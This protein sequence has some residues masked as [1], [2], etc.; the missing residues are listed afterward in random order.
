[1][2]SDTLDPQHYSRSSKHCGND[3][4]PTLANITRIGLAPAH[5]FITSPCPMQQAL[6]TWRACTANDPMQ[7]DEDDLTKKTPANSNALTFTS[8]LVAADIAP[9]QVTSL[10]APTVSLRFT[11][12]MIVANIEPVNEA[13][14]VPEVVTVKPTVAAVRV[15]ADYAP[16]DPVD[17]SSADEN[18][19]THTRTNSTSSA[20]STTST[21]STQTTDSHWSNSTSTTS[22]TSTD[23]KTQESCLK[24]SLKLIPDIVVDDSLHCFA[25]TTSVMPSIAPSNAETSPEAV[26]AV[27]QEQSEAVDNAGGSVLNFIDHY[28]I[29]ADEITDEEWNQLMILEAIR[30]D[31]FSQELENLSFDTSTLQL[32]YDSDAQDL[33]DTSANDL[34]LS[35]LLPF[36]DEIDATVKAQ[37]ATDY[38][39]VE[40]MVEDSV[41]SSGIPSTAPRKFRVRTRNMAS[42]P[43]ARMFRIRGNRRS[44][45]INVTHSPHVR[46]IPNIIITE[47]EE[48]T[49]PQSEVTRDQQP[50]S[51]FDYATRSFFLQVPEPQQ[52]R[53]LTQAPLNS[54]FEFRATGVNFAPS[55]PNEKE[56]WLNKWAEKGRRGTSKASKW[57]IN[58]PT[59]RE[60]M[61]V[62]DECNF[63]PAIT[64]ETP[65]ARHLDNFGEDHHLKSPDSLSP[66][67]S[68]TSRLGRWSEA[69]EEVL[70]E[71]MDGNSGQKCKSLVDIEDT[72]QPTKS[73]RS[74]TT[75]HFDDLYDRKNE[76]KTHKKGC[77][78]EEGYYR[79]DPHVWKNNQ[80]KTSGIEETRL[81]GGTSEKSTQGEVFEKIDQSALVSA[82]CHR[83]GPDRFDRWCEEY[84]TPISEEIW[85]EI[86]TQLEEYHGAQSEPAPTYTEY[87]DVV[88][89]TPRRHSLPQET[90]P[91]RYLRTR[92]S[93]ER[94]EDVLTRLRLMHCRLE[95]WAEGKDNMRYDGDF[96]DSEEH[97]YLE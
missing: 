28:G 63:L 48:F 84:A 95:R 15:V 70:D 35:T 11:P 53:S 1:M 41:V 78:E 56:E 34:N 75:Y 39:Q 58:A 97:E 14:E 82:L 60:T 23:S 16:C 29:D 22:L 30:G 43:C 44:P 50:D 55:S 21:A 61:K 89:P 47:P 5:A 67:A 10:S 91:R 3:Y 81:P 76:G 12:N 32:A 42:S 66:P 86:D 85:D 65:G 13:Q 72:K 24:N 52:T 7:V 51:N 46:P 57:T 17:I 31:V 8:I 36:A 88:I 40:A 83:W 9:V 27:P 37:T 59:T 93:L 74:K 80:A 4:M 73:S 19:P 96:L 25:M 49:K 94:K 62:E 68:G 2:G 92:A 33:V 54:E 71:L 45:L 87:Q 20:S 18:K 38:R 77:C 90:H 64:T 26:M 79:N 69:E 6:L